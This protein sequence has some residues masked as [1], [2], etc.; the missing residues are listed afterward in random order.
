ML[1]P[2]AVLL[3]TSEQSP[4]VAP[5]S[6]TLCNPRPWA[7]PVYSLPR[8]S[9]TSQGCFRAHAPFSCPHLMGP[10]SVAL[11]LFPMP[12]PHLPQPHASSSRSEAF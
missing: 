7:T 6:E 8:P 10:S 1:A 3:G 4:E 5:S 9:L 11:P 2:S 12:A